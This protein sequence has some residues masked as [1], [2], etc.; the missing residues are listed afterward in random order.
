MDNPQ[1]ELQIHYPCRLNQWNRHGSG[2]KPIV[3]FYSYVEMVGDYMNLLNAWN[4]PFPFIDHQKITLKV[5][6]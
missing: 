2:T 5:K 4:V 6:G 3:E 1:A